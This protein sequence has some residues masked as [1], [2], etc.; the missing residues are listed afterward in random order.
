[1][2]PKKDPKGIN[3][4]ITQAK[5]AIGSGGFYGKGFLKGYNKIWFRTAQATDFIF[6]NIAEEY[7]FVGSCV[8]IL[9]FLVL[10]LKILNM[11]ERQK[12]ALRVF[13][14]ILYFSN[15]SAFYY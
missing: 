14:D 10:L 11:A 5:I 8:V 1:M 12:S 4:N 13:M 7:G 9:L 3:W 15:I 2:N 6:S